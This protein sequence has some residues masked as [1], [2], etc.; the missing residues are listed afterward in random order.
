MCLE[1]FVRKDDFWRLDAPLDELV[2]ELHEVFV[3]TARRAHED[4]PAREV[5]ECLERR[6]FRPRHDD[7]VDVGQ[8]RRREVG[9][10][11]TAL[12]FR[13]VRRNEIRVAVQ[14][15]GEQLVTTERDDGNVDTDV[16]AAQF[17]V[18]VVL[19]L[20]QKVVHG[21]FRRA[22]II[23][24]LVSPGEVRGG[25]RPW[26]CRAGRRPRAARVARTGS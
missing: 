3:V 26:S 20:L 7:L 1:Q 2:H 18:E 14:K 4:F 15:R 5:V 9:K 6:R 10:L 16:S 12:R 25:P 17:L 21:A 13:D 11:A 24:E 22:G 8:Q 23:V 19:E